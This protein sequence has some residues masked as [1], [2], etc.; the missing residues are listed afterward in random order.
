MQRKK[1]SKDLIFEKQT[2]HFLRDDQSPITKQLG[3]T[4]ALKELFWKNIL[5]FQLSCD[6]NSNSTELTFIYSKKYQNCDSK[7]AL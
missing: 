4:I 3:K 6:G 2:P 7:N 1:H 5:P